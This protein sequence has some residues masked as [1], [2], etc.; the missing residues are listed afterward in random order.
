MLSFRWQSDHWRIIIKGESQVKLCLERP[1]WKVNMRIL[2]QCYWIRNG[3]LAR[4]TLCG[5]WS[6]QNIL[7]TLQTST[8]KKLSTF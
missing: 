5:S 4:G 7:H 1:L 3:D 2:E 6:K 8:L